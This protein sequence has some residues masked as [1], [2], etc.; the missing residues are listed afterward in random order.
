MILD[1]PVPVAP[2][3]LPVKL[4]CDEGSHPASVKNLR[5][6]GS[7]LGRRQRGI[8]LLHRTGW[9]LAFE[10]IYATC[11]VKLGDQFFCSH[12]TGPLSQQAF[13]IRTEQTKP[14][15]EGN[16]GHHRRI[17]KVLMTI[18]D[19]DA[20]RRDQRIDGSDEVRIWIRHGIQALATESARC[21][22][23]DQDRSFIDLRF[24]LSLFQAFMPTD[25]TLLR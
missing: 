1:H 20:N 6:S 22:E 21:L 16:F 15:R 5:C 13:A 7:T 2:E 9:I 17:T 23:D 4:P 12:P 14:R 19:I 3:W 8:E 25:D 10:Q 24:L 18:G 11:D